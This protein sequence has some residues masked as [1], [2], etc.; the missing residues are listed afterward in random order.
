MRTIL[1]DDAAKVL[2]RRR[3]EEV[4][5]DLEIWGGQGRR[6]GDGPLEH[7]ETAARCMMEQFLDDSQAGRAALMIA[8]IKFELPAF[9]RHRSERLPRAPQALCGWQMRGP[10]RRRRPLPW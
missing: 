6:E 3:Y 4:W 9:Q 1:E 10:P 8:T 5:A 2:T 7:D